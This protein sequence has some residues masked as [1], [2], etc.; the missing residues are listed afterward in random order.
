[1]SWEAVAGVL[2]V[3]RQAACERFSSHERWDRTH[4]LSQLRQARRAAMFRRMASGQSEQ[5]TRTLQKMMQT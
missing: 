4:R 3:S 2:G 5:V 1:M